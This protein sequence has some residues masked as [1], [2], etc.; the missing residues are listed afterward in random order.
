MSA[1]DRKQN[2]L[3]VDDLHVHY[4]SPRGSIIAANGVSFSLRKGEILG[5][6]GESGCGKTTVAM[7]ILRMIQPPGRIVHGQIRI[8]GQDIVGLSER[9]MRKVRWQELALVPQGAMNSLNPVTR[10]REQMG[11]AIT[12]HEAVSREQL[13]ERIL[14][15]M[16]DVGLPERVISM[17]PHELSGGMK[18][19]VCIAMSIALNPKVI[20]ADEPTSALDVV[21]QRVV[22][23]TLL[24]VKERLGVSMVLI[25]H[26]MGLQAQLVDR[27]AVMYAGNLVEVAPVIA[28]F[29]NPLHPY[30]Q[31]LIE[32]IPS[33]KE[34]KP[35][36]VTEGITH[37][38]RNP[39]PGC[40]F[41]FRCMWVEQKCR[42][43]APPMMEMADNHFVA[44]WQYPERYESTKTQSDLTLENS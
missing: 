32:S 43:S 29:E 15:L 31:I 27:I 36:K 18:Q 9:A 16:T 12:T 35:L 33:I 7:A 30:T 19:R 3:V 42:E 2:A 39:P 1:V 10:I 22:A 20:I 34:R 24:D 21:V 44:C 4:F 40:I 11:D 6:V 8:D 26:D 5:L 37:D 41:Q 25:G 23:Q 17:Y 13:R 28:A 14:K 38:L